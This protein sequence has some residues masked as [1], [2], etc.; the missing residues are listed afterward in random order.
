MSD[1]LAYERIHE[2]MMNLKM[3]AVEPVIDSMLEQAVSKETSFV[4]ILDNI[5]VVPGVANLRNSEKPDQFLF[6]HNCWTRDEFT[7]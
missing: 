1:S 2:N 5:P 3:N 7:I 4:E 6:C